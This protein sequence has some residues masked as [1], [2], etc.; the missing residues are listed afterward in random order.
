M[1][2]VFWMWV[3]KSRGYGRQLREYVV[4]IKGNVLAS[5][6]LFFGCGWEHFVGTG[7]N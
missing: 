3:G 5:W 2:P 7:N 1:V 4:N 6:C